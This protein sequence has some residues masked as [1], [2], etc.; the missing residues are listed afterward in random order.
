[1]IERYIHQSRALGR[2]RSN[3]LGSCMDDFTAYLAERRHTPKTIHLY[4]RAVAHFARWLEKQRLNPTAIAEST[5]HLFL[6][7]HLRHCRCVPPGIRGVRECRAA[8]RLFLDALRKTGRIPILIPPPPTRIGVEIAKF[9]D[10]LRTTCGF[11]E[12]TVLYR[13]RY[14]NEFLRASFGERPLKFADLTPGDITEFIRERSRRYKPH[15]TKVVASSRRSYMRFLRLRGEISRDLS[16]AVPAVAAWKQAHLPRTLSDEQI[17]RFFSSFDRSTV[18]GRRDY[19]ICL[20]LFELGLRTSDVSQL[21]LDDINWRAGTLC[22]CNIKTQRSR[23]LPLP[24]RLGLAIVDYLRNGRPE[25]T[26]RHIFLL[27]VAPRGIGIGRRVVQHAVHT[28]CVRAGFNVPFSPH[29]FRHTLAS[30][31][32]EKG[33]TFKEIADILGHKK[34]DTVSI[35]AKVSMTGLSKVALPWP[36]VRP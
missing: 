3:P 25:S 13:I 19:A 15:S 4:V 1:M 14:V 32:Y 21:C 18:T 30:S 22:V 10:Y 34:I 9:E 5:V 31:L 17:C 33:A 11:A 7:K 26:D 28:A 36:E 12:N 23:L 2:L 35:Y 29:V 16:A 27:H 8:L 20:C 24:E 6:N